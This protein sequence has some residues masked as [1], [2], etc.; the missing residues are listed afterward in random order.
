MSALGS[1]HVEVAV[2][3]SLL[4]LDPGEKR[5]GIA[6]KPAGERGSTPL[7]VVA[8]DGK[9]FPLVSQ[10]ARE[11]DAD[12]V[13]VGLPRD[14]N[15]NDTAQTAKA[16]AFAGELAEATGLHV[17]MHDEFTTSERARERLGKLTREQEKRQLDAVAA[18]ILLED[19]IES[20]V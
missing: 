15:G 11:H 9:L 20:L 12:T 17:L 1:E 18:G 14:I 7:C 8:P 19:Y 13:V 4:G 6:V 3:Q 16:R 2:E 5:I 10:L